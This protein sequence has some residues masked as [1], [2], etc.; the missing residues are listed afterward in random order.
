MKYVELMKYKVWFSNI[1]Y[2]FGTIGTFLMLL[3]SWEYVRPQISLLFPDG[4]GSQSVV[5]IYSDPS[6]VTYSVQK[7][8]VRKS[9]SKNYFALSGYVAF[10]T[11]VFLTIVAD[12]KADFTSSGIT[13]VIRPSSSSLLPL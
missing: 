10:S 5:S 6:V 4:I 8:V 1:L 2:Y 13:L 11:I 12:H 3:R 9:L 7:S